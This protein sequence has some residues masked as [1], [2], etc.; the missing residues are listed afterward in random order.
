M[1]IALTTKA[2]TRVECVSF[3]NVYLFVPQKCLVICPSKRSI[4]LSLKKVYSSVPQKGPLICPSKR[5]TYL[6]CRK[7]YLF[8]PKKGLPICPSKRSTWLSFKNVKKVQLCLKS[9]QIIGNNTL[10]IFLSRIIW[11][12]R[13]IVVSNVILVHCSK[14]S[15]KS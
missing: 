10:M 13:R 1:Q 9:N 3:K 12:L 8:V 15:N 11:H 7:V 2:L 6:S 5:S 4:H 14:M